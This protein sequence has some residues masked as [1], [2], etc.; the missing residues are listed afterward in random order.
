MPASKLPT[1]K[2]RIAKS[3]P[4]RR[5]VA[6]TAMI[7]ARVSPALKSEAESILAKIG[8]SASDAIRLFYRQ[9]TLHNGVPFELH[10]PNATTSRTLRDADAGKNLKKYADTR[11]LFRKLK[12]KGGKE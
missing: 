12:I 6:K 5:A 4:T 7:R 1:S 10:I 2:A 3:T 9:V 8:L 11:E